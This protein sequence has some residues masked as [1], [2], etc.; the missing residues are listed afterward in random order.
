LIFFIFINLFFRFPFR[1]IATITTRTSQQ[2][3]YILFHTLQCIQIQPNQPYTF[4]KYDLNKNDCEYTF[5]LSYIE[6]NDVMKLINNLHNINKMLNPQKTILLNQLISECEQKISFESSWIVDIREKHLLQI[7]IIC[8]TITPLLMIPGCLMLTDQRLYFQ[9]FN[10]INTEP[11]IRYELI[12]IKQIYKRRH[13]MRDIGLEIYFINKNKHSESINTH[14]S[15]YLSFHTTMERD[16]ICELI[17]TQTIYQPSKQQTLLYTTQQWI[18]GQISNYDYLLFINMFAGRS[19]QDLTQYPVFPWIISDYTSTQLDL[20]N[21]SSFRDL[22]KPIGALNEQRLEMFKKRYKD[23]P[24]ELCNNQ[25]FLYGTHYSTPGYVLFYLVRKYP[26]YQLKLQNGR[27]D[28][29]DRLFFSMKSTWESCLTGPA[30]VKELIPEFYSLDTNGDFLVN[31][32][33]LEFGDRQNGNN[34]IYMSGFVLW[35]KYSFVVYFCLFV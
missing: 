30:D 29:S 3:S 34:I 22:S 11:V 26:Q 14:H 9:S 20:T 4:I 6:L 35:L 33:G 8:S 19:F 18:L 27:F 10:N 7:P 21:E 24:S 28:Q 13:I 12:D 16:S 15:I 5:T 23:M 1:D 25:P 17:H 32:F 31:E 2:T